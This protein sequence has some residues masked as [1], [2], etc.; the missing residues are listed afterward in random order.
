MDIE[1]PA[2]GTI[3]CFGQRQ[4]WCESRAVWR[5][6]TPRLVL[7]WCDECKKRENVQTLAK[8]G[9]FIEMSPAQEQKSR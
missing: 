9:A 8:G 2:K 3:A 7:H 4:E 6:E 1:Y 5:M